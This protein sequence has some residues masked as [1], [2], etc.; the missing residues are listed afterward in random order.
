MSIAG[1]KTVEE[2]KSSNVAVAD[3]AS[4]G[5]EQSAASATSCCTPKA[6]APLPTATP[7]KTGCGCAGRKPEAPAADEDAAGCCSTEEVASP[8]TGAPAQRK[9]PVCGMTVTVQSPHV[10]QHE[11]KSVYFCSAGCKT[12]FIADPAK[13][14][15]PLEGAAAGPVSEAPAAAGT[16][17]TC[18]MHPEIRQDHPGS[19]PKCGMALEPDMPSLEEGDSP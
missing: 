15:T 5:A 13:F 18:P 12:K 7:A 8:S 4:A 10:H 3:Q 9:D 16:I 2:H 17:F 14:M 6:T 19:C 11:G 1:E